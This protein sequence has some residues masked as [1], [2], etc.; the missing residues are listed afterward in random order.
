MEKLAEQ[1]KVTAERDFSRVLR[2]TSA[3]QNRVKELRKQGPD[4]K[5]ERLNFDIRH[6]QHRIQPGWRQGP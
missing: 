4:N 6:V 5:R 1:K 2:P 3:Q